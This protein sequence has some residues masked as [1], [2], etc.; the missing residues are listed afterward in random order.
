MILQ[1]P[2]KRIKRHH[3][4]SGDGTKNTILTV[5]FPDDL[6]EQIISFTPIKRAVNLSLLSTRF[7]NSWR[8]S[9]NLC[10]DQEF[11]RGHD[12]RAR[13]E[14]INHILNLHLGNKI[15]EFSLYI[16]LTDSEGLFEDLIKK[17][18]TKHVEELDL[19][20]SKGRFPIF[21][22]HYDLLDVE[23]IRAL[24]LTCCSL[25]FPPRFKGLCFLKTL[26]L[27]GIATGL[28]KFIKTLFSN[29]L[30]IERLELVHCEWVSALVVEALKLKNFKVS[31][32]RNCFNLASISIDALNLHSFHYHGEVSKVKFH[33]KMALL[34]DVI[35]NFTH[36]R[37]FSRLREIKDLMNSL[38]SVSVLTVSGAFLEELS[39]KFV[40]EELKELPFSLWHLK[41]LQL[42]IGTSFI[43]LFDIASFLKNC[44]CLESLFI[45][46]G[47]FSFEH[48][49][50]W[51][52]HA[53]QKFE[54]CEPSFQ[55]L[56]FIKLK[57][58]KCEKLVFMMLKFFLRKARF[59]ETLVLVSAKK[60]DRNY[61]DNLCMSGPSFLPASSLARIEVYSHS[62]DKSCMRPTHTKDCS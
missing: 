6:L 33:S 28:I 39:L 31:H 32:V 38:A 9:R 53:K 62:D 61:F 12:E 56:K 13:I 20:F 49:T 40:N 42:W 58:L 5:N 44:P 37:S 7:K 59:L 57:G 29:C 60:S 11:A 30:L 4:E 55:A 19:D 34:N 14:M 18:T 45:D 25:D 36:T 26:I 27:Q 1:S 48:S 22:L 50:Y 51:E 52:C 35:L 43:N 24:R 21:K 41:E 2:E 23:S 8:Y 46:M 17:V 10:F 47:G 54:Q 3:H 15:Q 16:D